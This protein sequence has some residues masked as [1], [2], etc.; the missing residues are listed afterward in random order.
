MKRN[1]VS[2]EVLWQ[3]NDADAAQSRAGLSGSPWR[4]LRAG[5]GSHW[6][7]VRSLSNALPDRWKGIKAINPVIARETVSRAGKRQ[8][9]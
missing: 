5:R 4:R 9:K 1:P 7:N 6:L 8:P 3:G 2:G